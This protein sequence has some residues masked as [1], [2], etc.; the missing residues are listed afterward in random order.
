MSDTAHNLPPTHSPEMAYQAS[1]IDVDPEELVDA[2]DEGEDGTSAF[3]CP[4][5]SYRRP[6]R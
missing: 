1:N 2:A 5:L 6:L 3:S 4:S